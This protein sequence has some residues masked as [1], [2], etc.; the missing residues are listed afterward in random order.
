MNDRKSFA[1]VGLRPQP[2]MTVRQP[3]RGGKRPWV[4]A[5]ILAGIVLGC[6]FAEVLSSVDPGYMDLGNCSVKPCSR[7][8]FGTDS[9]GRDIF[10]GIWH[11]GRIS[12]AI[13][14]LA[15]LISTILAMI[16]GTASG[17]AP[18]W[19]DALIM[20]L[21]DILLS[22]PSLLM[23]LFLQALFGDANVLS[24]AVVIGITNWT[25]TARIIRTEV[26][27]LRSSGYVVASRSMGGGFFHIM[28]RHLAPN[29]I[30]PV[31]FALVMNVRSAIV[32]ESTLSFLGMGLPL[33]TVSWGS[34][35]SLAES[36]LM[37]GSWWMVLIPGVF[38]VTLLM[39][40]TNI[41]NYLRKSANR[42]DSYL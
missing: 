9:L 5:G 20:R 17:L 34:M 7:F 3:V 37:A 24:L 28:C 8:F 35:L 16:I 41:G 13:G 32:A 10:S 1:L 38:L 40:L 25:G 15:T 23:V 29:F 39:C 4:S 27:R 33:E 11:G 30:A 14:F 36:S 19:L 21:T 2:R 26:C 18:A 12:I 6:L 31:M 22:I 42:K